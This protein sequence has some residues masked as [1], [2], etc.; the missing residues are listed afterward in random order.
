MARQRAVQAEIGGRVVE[1][2]QGAE[3]FRQF[4][5]DGTALYRFRTA[6]EQLRINSDRILRD[7]GPPGTLVG[8][9]IGLAIPVSLFA[10]AIVLAWNQAAFTAVMAAL[11][12]VARISYPLTEVFARAEGLAPR[13][14]SAARLRDL[15]DTPIPT[16]GDPPAHAASSGRTHPGVV[17]LDG[18]S[19]RYPNGRLALDA[20]D[21][22]LAPGS[23]TAVVGPS[24]AGKSTLVHLIA[25]LLTPSAGSVRIG[26]VDVSALDE[27]T[28][29]EM[30]AAVLQDAWLFS[31]SIA[32]NI[33]LA[34][35]EATRAEIVAVAGATGC[36]AFV[37]EL[38]EGYD[39]R[40]GE[41][42]VGLSGGQ[43][44]QL[45]LARALL[46]N[47]PVLLLDEMTAAVDPVTEGILRDAVSAAA[48]RRTV[49]LVAHRLSMVR[50]ADQIVVLDAGRI[51]ERGTHAE[52][53]VAGGIYQQLWQRWLTSARW[54]LTRADRHAP[55]GR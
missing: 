44:Q 13:E 5:A 21:L 32:D 1:Y 24:G 35:P 54:Q 4:G 30:V 48:V 19:L 10:A 41:Q 42:G 53:A 15:L 16:I 36:H 23:V 27:L 46:K 14:A 51:V 43:R 7:V 40:I 49:L 18:V 52:L 31:G 47:A 26:G 8:T 12:L 55:A 22:R 9:M 6:V 33:A 37:S 17:E 25:G 28:R 39:T 45:A 20:V 38:P 50:H 11:I 29:A 34:R 2:V 3:V